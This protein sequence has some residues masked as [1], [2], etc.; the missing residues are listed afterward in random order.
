MKIIVLS[1]FEWPYWMLNKANQY[2]W[3]QSKLGLFHMH[4]LF[5]AEK[6]AS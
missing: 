1:P 6:I 2:K 4:M 5:L 3:E